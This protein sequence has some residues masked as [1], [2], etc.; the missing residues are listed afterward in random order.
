MATQAEI[1][2]EIA[3]YLGVTTADIDPQSS[4]KDDLGMSPIEIAD[5]LNHLAGKFEITFNQEETEEIS[6][7][8]DLLVMVEDLLLE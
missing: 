6:T 8:N 1:I 2:E 5:L 3:K 4:L 7:V